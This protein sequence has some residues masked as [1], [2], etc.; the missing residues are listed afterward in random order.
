MFWSGIVYRNSEFGKTGTID[1][2]LYQKHKTT[3]TDR[4]WSKPIHLIADK[5][6]GALGIETSFLGG[7]AITVKCLV[8]SGIGAG[9][10]S[11]LF[12]CP[13]VGTYGVVAEIPD[14]NRFSNSTYIWLGGL[15][16]CKDFG[17]KVSVPRDDTEDE[18][19]GEDTQLLDEAI[20]DSDYIKKGA[21]ILKTK[22]TT[23]D[24]YKNIDKEK[25]NIENIL[26]ENTVF[27]NKEKIA[28]KHH[29]IKDEAEIGFEKL[30]M[31]EE[32]VELKRTLTDKNVEQNLTM[33]ENGVT[34][35]LKSDDGEATISLSSTLDL[36]IKTTGKMTVSS[37]KDLS[38]SSDSNIEVNAGGNINFKSSG[39]MAIE[40][41][42]AMGIKSKT[43]SLIELLDTLMQNLMSLKTIGSPATQTISPDTQVQIN[44]VKQNL[45]MSFTK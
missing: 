4:F 12:S 22:T 3:G 13:Q 24:D 43:K 27:L 44:M 20:K 11:G 40:S 14:R 35:Q 18:I 29:L 36:D 8:M 26:P 23:I 7:S 45:G 10:N 33:D 15:Y 19:A 16:G 21:F 28:I 1:V 38:F 30:T 9:E 32:K 42:G 34:L 31:N 41:T 25:I 39:D 6:K 37:E 17:K 2:M 5:I